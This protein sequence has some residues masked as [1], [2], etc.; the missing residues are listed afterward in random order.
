MRYM[1]T[2]KTKP[3]A[4]SPTKNTL[5]AEDGD[6]DDLGPPELADEDSD[7]PTDI[8]FLDPREQPLGL[9]DK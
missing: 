3:N 2:Q 1:T 6:E 8:P 5:K 4:T 7:P 9:R